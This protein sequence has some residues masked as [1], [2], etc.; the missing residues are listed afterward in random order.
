V[1]AGSKIQSF[2]TGKALGLI[3][4]NFLLTLRMLAAEEPY[5][6]ELKGNRVAPDSFFTVADE[7]FGSSAWSQIQQNISVDNIISFE[8][9]FDTSIFFYNTPFTCTINFD[10]DV[11]N[12]PSDTSAFTT[13]ED[14][15][16]FVRYDTVTGKPYKG[17]ALYKFVG[18]H[19]FKVRINTVTSTELSPMLPIF[20]LKGQVIVNRK[21]NF[22]DNST[23]VTRYTIANGNQLK[24]EWTPSNYPGAEMFDLEYTHIDKNSQVAASINGYESGGNYSVPVDSLIKWL[25]NN[26]TRITTAASNYLINIPYDSGFILFRIRGVQIHFPDDVRWEGNWNYYARLSSA[27]SC[28]PP[29]CPSGVVFF[30][31]HEQNLNWQFS[32]VFAEEGKRKEVI[33]YFD[34]SL[35]NRQSVT[36]NNTDNRNIVQETIYDALG[37]PSLNILPS[38]TKDSTIHYFRG[39]NKNKE[40][41]P[42]AFPIYYITVQLLPTH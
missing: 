8:I 18:Y 5:L 16:L 1:I 27:S 13:I 22:Q 21:Y 34:G 26:N 11:Y 24:L 28:T 25:K 32:V 33:S 38:P 6:N 15:S 3:L 37:R 10:I 42:L 17:I 35:R 36:L 31:G 12:N 30:A 29:S 41:A 39:F 7:K 4:I 14:I 23:D 40:G 2:L 9:N 20:R 19:K